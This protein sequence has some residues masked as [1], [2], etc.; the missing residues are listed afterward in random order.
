MG[1][2][3]ILR[4]KGYTQ[5]RFYCGFY[6]TLGGLVGKIGVDRGLAATKLRQWLDVLKDYDVSRA[7][8]AEQVPATPA[9]LYKWQQADESP[10]SLPYLVR[11]L[12]VLRKHMPKQHWNARIALDWATLLGYTWNDINEMAQKGKIQYR[13]KGTHF[14]KESVLIGNE[15][16][17]FLDWW[18]SSQPRYT[19]KLDHRRLTENYIERAILEQICR[20]ITQWRD[21]QQLQYRGIVLWG[22]GGA[23]KTTL[24]QALALDKRMQ[25][26]YHDGILWID[27]DEE[28]PEKW[29]RL[30]CE[31][32]D[33]KKEEQSWTQTWQWWAGDDNHRCLVVLDGL[34]PGSNIEPLIKGLGSQ[35]SFLIATQTP[36][37]FANKLIEQLSPETVWLKEIPELQPKE[38]IELVGKIT[39]QE[40]DDETLDVLQ[41]VK[42]Q[43]GWT[44]ELVILAAVRVRVAFKVQKDN[45]VELK[46]ALQEGDITEEADLAK[47]HLELIRTQKAEAYRWLREILRIM[48]HPWPFGVEYGMAIWNISKEQ[49]TDRF[50]R[51]TSLGLL[52]VMGKRTTVF[53]ESSPMWRVY[54]WVRTI[55]SESNEHSK[56][57]R[58]SIRFSGARFS[59]RLKPSKAQVQMHW[60]TPLPSM[61][62]ITLVL[63]KEMLF[64]CYYKLLRAYQTWSYARWTKYAQFS[65]LA[66]TKARQKELKDKY[67]LSQEYWLLELSHYPVVTYSPWMAFVLLL[68]N[69]IPLGVAKLLNVLVGSRFELMFLLLGLAILNRLSTVILIIFFLVVSWL[70]AKLIWRLS[71]IGVDTSASRLMRWINRIL[72][73]MKERTINHE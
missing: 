71:W 38:V 29:P 31:A 42:R 53:G 62:F 20:K 23:G 40:I 60:L 43:V 5:C 15:K 9:A 49:A 45:W 46:G 26:F 7:E 51:L 68:M 8:I 32:L 2:I 48:E 56:W 12:T 66:A 39:L 16:E 52:E 44:P 11:L 4:L 73:R 47:G 6:D 35:T 36:R 41:A 33:L 67:G 19:L 22:S 25:E 34:T 17:A 58:E 59:S 28:K 63:L 37:I 10:I 72:V 3:S 54:P 27:A 69:M 65:I 14:R 18:L 50:M 70:W 61:V 57:K 55:S 21:L 30:L 13:Q 24:A 64:Y 1:E